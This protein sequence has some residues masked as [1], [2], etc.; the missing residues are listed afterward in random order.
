MTKLL[1][2]GLLT[3]NCVYFL[4]GILF[5]ILGILISFKKILRRIKYENLKLKS[6]R[7]SV[8]MSQ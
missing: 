6:A 5:I 8:D 7:A 1:E 2:N 3:Y 4:L